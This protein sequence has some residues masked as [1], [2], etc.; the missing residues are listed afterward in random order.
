MVSHL[1]WIKS[2]RNVCF[3]FFFLFLFSNS[4]DEILE[5]T[6]FWIAHTNGFCFCFTYSCRYNS[7]CFCCSL[8][9]LFL[10]LLLWIPLPKHFITELFLSCWC[11]GYLLFVIPCMVWW[12]LLCCCFLWGSANSKT[13]P[14]PSKQHH[15]IHNK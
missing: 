4:F 2:K 10:H 5:T 11:Y 7:C 3:V 6:N 15:T 8:L 9:L 14:T 13:P 1:K 12:Y